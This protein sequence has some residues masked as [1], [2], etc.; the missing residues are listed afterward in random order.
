[1]KRLIFYD[2]PGQM[3]N[4]FWSYIDSVGWAIENRTK[5]IVL[6]WDRSLKDFERLRNS[7]YI[8]FPFYSESLIKIL[9][10]QRYLE[11]LKHTFTNKYARFVY[12]HFLRYFCTA[13][14]SYDL[15]NNHNFYPRQLNKIREMF[16]PDQS[17][18]TTVDNAFEKWRMSG[19]KV[20]GMHVRRGDYKNWRGI[21]F[22][23]TAN[24]IAL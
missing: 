4:R 7:E 1:M 21:I 22:T 13:V 18:K 15:H 2:S 16:S 14:R 11:I 8:K 10:E 9:G 5:V 6:F 23:P 3:C 19:F 17:I 12:R 24:I 20:V